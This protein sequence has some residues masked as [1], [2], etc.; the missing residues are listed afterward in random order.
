MV[1]TRAGSAARYYA[2]CV[3]GCLLGISRR[4]AL[5]PVNAVQDSLRRFVPHPCIVCIP[6][7]LKVNEFISTVV[8]GPAGASTAGKKYYEQ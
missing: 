6:R 3:T 8:D 1:V 5:G 2:V 4:I 7:R